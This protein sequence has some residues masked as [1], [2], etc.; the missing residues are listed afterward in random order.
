MVG[1]VPQLTQILSSNTRSAEN[2]GEIVKSMPQIIYTIS[3]L[4]LSQ[5]W[6]GFTFNSLQYTDITLNLDF[7]TFDE[8]LGFYQTTHLQINL[9]LL[10]S[11][12]L[13]Q[14]IIFNKCLC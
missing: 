2:G 12:Q 9:Y 4:V 3:V 1:N 7:R 13:A 6:Y 14:I 5:P 8:Y 10:V 11:I